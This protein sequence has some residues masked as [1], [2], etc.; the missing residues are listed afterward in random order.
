MLGESGGFRKVVA[1]AQGGILRDHGG[2]GQERPVQ[3]EVTRSFV[4]ERV[5]DQRN[6]V[7]HLFAQ[8]AGVQHRLRY[9]VVA[10]YACG[11]GG[12]QGDA[13]A[14]ARGAFH[15]PDVRQILVVEIFLQRSIVVGGIPHRP[16]DDAIFRDVDGDIFG[17]RGKDIASPGRF[18]AHQSAAGC[19]DADGAPTVAGMGKG[20][21]TRSHQG[22]RPCGGAP[23]GI[24]GIP[25]V[26]RVA[27]LQ[28][29]PAGQKAVFRGAALAQYD[30]AGREYLPDDGVVLFGRAG[31]YTAAPLEG[32]QPFHIVQVLDESG[33]PCKYPFL[34][35][36]G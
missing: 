6:L 31:F 7:S 26:V 17:R 14:F 20:Y 23:R 33:N 2:E 5:V 36:A 28:G 30:A 22:S 1:E 12:K 35:M 9:G 16:A 25:G 21:Y 18:E 24:A 11:G 3:Q 34:G 32:G 29:F 4:A 19:R 10:V 13:Q 15:Q 8:L 27:V